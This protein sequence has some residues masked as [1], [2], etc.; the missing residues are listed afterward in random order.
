MNT[1]K[2]AILI[3]AIALMLY[4]LVPGLSWEKGVSALHE[5]G[6]SSALPACGLN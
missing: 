2:I 4:I 6:C 5:A 3:L 1:T